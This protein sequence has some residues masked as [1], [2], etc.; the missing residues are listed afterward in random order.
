MLEAFAKLQMTVSELL[1]YKAIEAEKSSAW[2]RHY[3]G[4]AWRQDHKTCIQDGMKVHDQLLE[5]IDGVTKM[6]AALGRNLQ[7]LVTKES[8]GGMDSMFGGFGDD[9]S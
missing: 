2:F 6:E 9:E 7:T 1:E 4:G 8:G 3:D 5:A